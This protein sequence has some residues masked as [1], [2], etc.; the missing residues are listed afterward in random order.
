ML[1]PPS[2]CS[3]VQ[4]NVFPLLQKHYSYVVKPFQQLDKY[5]ALLAGCMSCATL[6]WLI[7]SGVTITATAG[8]ASTAAFY[9]FV[10][11]S[12]TH[13]VAKQLLEERTFHPENNTLASYSNI[14][15]IYLNAVVGCTY[16]TIFFT[17][18]FFSFTPL[19]AKYSML[20]CAHSLLADSYMER[21]KTIYAVT[22][23]I[24]SSL[25]LNLSPSSGIACALTMNLADRWQSAHPPRANA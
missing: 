12:Q 10:L 15:R 17:V 6:A 1:A 8:A 18:N 14:A 20:V 16:P 4:Q 25:L 19:L 3:F 2:D 23:G 13:C 11:F 21:M 7:R 24:L 9:A 22:A 5:Q